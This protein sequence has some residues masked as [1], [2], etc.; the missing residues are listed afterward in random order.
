MNL[1]H[2]LRHFDD[3]AA[4]ARR[5]RGRADLVRDRRRHRAARRQAPAGPEP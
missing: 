3:Q 5:D 4:H 1:R 2:L